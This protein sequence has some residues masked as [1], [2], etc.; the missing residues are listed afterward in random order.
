MTIELKNK[1]KNELYRAFTYCGEDDADILDERVENEL[2]TLM[3]FM[4][5]S[6][7]D[8][9]LT[10]NGELTGYL[11]DIAVANGATEDDVVAL[12]MLIT[13]NSI[14]YIINSYTAV[15]PDGWLP[16]DRKRIENEHNRVVNLEEVDVS[17]FN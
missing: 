12:Q 7:P 16:G 3:C 5:G 8:I 1:I 10:D 17:I 15:K 2:D 14:R 9:I 6:D 13:K 11:V 4:A